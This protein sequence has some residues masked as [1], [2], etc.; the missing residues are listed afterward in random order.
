MTWCVCWVF[1]FYVGFS[2]RAFLSIP[3]TFKNSVSKRFLCLQTVSKTLFCFYFHLWTLKYAS[4]IENNKFRA[5]FDFLLC[6]GW[7]RNGKHRVWPFIQRQIDF[8]KQ[9]DQLSKPGR[10]PSEAVHVHRAIVAILS[11]TGNGHDLSRTTAKS[12][13]H[14]K[15]EQKNA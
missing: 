13:K 9:S 4:S 12:S 11:A 14:E 8:K 3:I 7:I 15:Q 5:C 2:E 6:L 10:F 1:V